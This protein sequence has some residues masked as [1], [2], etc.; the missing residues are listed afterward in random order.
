MSLLLFPQGTFGYCWRHWLSQLGDCYWKAPS[1][2]SAG[3]PQT[4]NSPAQ[5]GNSV[6]VK[7][8]HSRHYLLPDLFIFV[9]KKTILLIS[10]KSSHKSWKNDSLINKGVG[11]RYTVWWELNVTTH[12]LWRRGISLFTLLG[13]LS[14]KFHNLL[15]FGS[16]ANYNVL[17]MGDAD[18]LIAP[19]SPVQLHGND[20]EASQSRKRATNRV[21][22]LP[23]VGAALAPWALS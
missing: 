2:Q 19:T 22:V 3:Q 23:T 1:W 18:R 6:E 11:N 10:L 9:V 14:L 17:K 7:K 20:A 12:I 4:K 21:S 13:K 5:D 8:A 15:L 16:Y